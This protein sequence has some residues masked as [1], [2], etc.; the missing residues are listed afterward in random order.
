MHRS[1]ST[2]SRLFAI[3]TCIQVCRG[4]KAEKYQNTNQKTVPNPKLQLAI[5]FVSPLF[6]GG[7]FLHGAPSAGAAVSTGFFLPFF[8]SVILD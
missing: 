2:E 7:G 5:G 8:H 6:W 3:N 4:W 1:F